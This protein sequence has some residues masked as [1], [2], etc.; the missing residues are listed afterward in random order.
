MIYGDLSREI[1]QQMDQDPVTSSLSLLHYYLL[2]S[3][4]KTSI[5]KVVVHIRDS[6][7]NMI[8]FS[9]LFLQDVSSSH[10]NSASL[11]TKKWK[12]FLPD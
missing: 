3:E 1:V 10:T 6:A 2:I 11:R 8:N 12:P 9:H 7:P 4:M 5:F